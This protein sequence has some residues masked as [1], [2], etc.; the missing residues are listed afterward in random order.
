MSVLRAPM[1]ER[2]QDRAATFSAGV[3]PA[4]RGA[5]ATLPLAPA[6]LRTAIPGG[7]D[8]D[9]PPW[10]CGSAQ[11]PARASATLAV[12]TTHPRPDA[13]VDPAPIVEAVGWAKLGR[14]SIGG[15]ELLG[16]GLLLPIAMLVVGT[17]IALAVRLALW[18]VGLD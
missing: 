10:V 3:V 13:H 12:M 11:S 4:A 2:K 9:R 14:W 16:V 6:L 17:P 15:V 1:A 7:V 18:L 5:L 8:P